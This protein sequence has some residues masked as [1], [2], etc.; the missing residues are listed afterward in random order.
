[1]IDWRPGLIPNSQFITEYRQF[2]KPIVPFAS[3][4]ARRLVQGKRGKRPSP[5]GP[6]FCK[7]R[8]VEICR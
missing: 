1:M 7:G 8:G 5:P 3:D 4:Q 2:F 6:V